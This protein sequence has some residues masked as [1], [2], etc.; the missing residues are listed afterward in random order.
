MSLLLYRVLP[1]EVVLVHDTLTVVEDTYEPAI[2][3]T[4]VATLPHLGIA[5]AVQGDGNL[6]NEWPAMTN[7]SILASDIDQL[8]Q[9]AP[10]ALRTLWAARDDRCQSTAVYHFGWSPRDERFVRYTYRHGDAPTET[11]P[12]PP[13]FESECYAE[14]A[15]G[16]CPAGPVTDWPAT[17]EEFIGAAVAIRDYHD[18]PDTPDDTIRVPIGGDLIATVLTNGA[19]GD[20][21]ITTKKVHRFDDWAHDWAAMNVR[22]RRLRKEPVT[23]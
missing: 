19:R 5:I 20:A 2:F 7:D 13:D 22:L 23:P 4:K 17:V 11:S 14:D 16:I 1:D 21:L 8:D 18:Q 12:A 3:S 6:A 9:H 15:C 10:E